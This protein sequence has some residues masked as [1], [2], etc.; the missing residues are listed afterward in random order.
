MNESARPGDGPL[1][2]AHETGAATAQALVEAGRRLFATHGY[3]GASVRAITG[4]AGANLGAITYHYGSKRELYDR[5]V[6]SVV[7]PLAERVEAVVE[8]GGDALARA[9]GVVRSYFEYLSRNPDLPQ[10]MLQELAL[11]G[12]PGEAVAGPLRRVHAA[13]T[14]LIV[15]GQSAGVVRSGPAPVLG[16]FILSVPVHMGIL[17]RPM[18]HFLGLDVLD[19]ER[20]AAIVETAVAFVRGALRAEEAGGES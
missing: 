5:V 20:R 10:L 17:Q 2:Q 16:I 13:V 1:D 4:E 9:E 15:E 19:A 12:V 18:K 8:G 11:G 6:G 3:D 14:R 7:S